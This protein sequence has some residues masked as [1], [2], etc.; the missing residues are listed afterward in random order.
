MRCYDACDDIFILF[1]HLFVFFLSVNKS[2]RLRSCQSCHQDNSTVFQASA[3]GYLSGRCGLGC[4]CSHLGRV[5]GLQFSPL[6]LLLELSGSQG[7]CWLDGW[8]FLRRLVGGVGSFL[9]EIS[10]ACCWDSVV[11]QCPG[12]K[13][14]CILFNTSQHAYT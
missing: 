5:S 7:L 14:G 3:A 4:A 12:L 8:L 11:L 13:L 6:V 9:F 10:P 2:S 1:L